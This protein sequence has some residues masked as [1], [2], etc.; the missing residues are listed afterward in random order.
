MSSSAG[1][2]RRLRKAGTRG[3]PRAERERQILEVAGHE[4][5]SRGYHA[6]SM[7]DIAQR[8]G[9][10]KPIVY[11]YFGSKDGLYLAYVERAGNE[12]LDRMRAAGDPSHEP[13]AR[14]RAGTVEFLNFVAER[15]DGWAVLYAEAAAQGGP[16]AEQLVELRSRVAHMIERLLREA[17]QEHGENPPADAAL[18]G[19]ANALVGAGES[20]ANW[21]LGHQRQE[22][23][24]VANWLVAFGRAAVD[25]TVAQ[26][27]GQS[28]RRRTR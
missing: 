20:L 11:A 22:A 21:W 16:L 9:V 28:T 23:E 27:N 10:S 12:L 2:R 7:D 19:I 6:V 5:A 18:N 8:A 24:E 17:F 14:L 13:Q 4:F 3:V 25:E 15:R 1:T 26:P